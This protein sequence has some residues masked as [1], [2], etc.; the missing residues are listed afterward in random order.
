MTVEL[1]YGKKPENRAEQDVLVDLYDYLRTQPDH[2]VM[3]STFELNHEIDLVVLKA[4]AWFVVEI[5]HVW[6]KVIGSKNGDWKCIN[7]NGTV[8]TLRNP[9]RQVRDSYFGLRDWVQANLS[10]VKPAPASGKE[11][12]SQANRAV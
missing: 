4:S 5:K 3:L 12:R 8:K 10:H 11:P 6:G 2:Y 1:W 7:P 9:F